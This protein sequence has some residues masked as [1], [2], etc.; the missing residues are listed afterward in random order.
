MGW[1][2]SALFVQGSP[3][4]GNGRTA[5][6]GAPGPRPG[7]GPGPGPAGWSGR[8]RRPRA[9]G[10]VLFAAEVGG[11]TQVWDPSMELAPACSPPGNA[12]T[13]VFSSVASSYA[14]TLF[15]GGEPCGRLVYA[16]A[17][18][19]RHR[20]PLPVESTVEI[21]SWGPDEDF[22]WAVIESVTGTGYPSSAQFQPWWR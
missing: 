1:N 21:P 13:V 2:T 5:G 11:W 18:A 3:R 12:L 17:N 22:V 10:G 7:S 9:R 16:D 20:H 8:T 15:A 14:Y 6:H 4:L 19:S